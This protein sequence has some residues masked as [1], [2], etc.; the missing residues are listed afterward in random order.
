M[1]EHPRRDGYVTAASCARCHTPLTG[2]TD[3]RYCSHTCRQAAYRTRTATTPAPA[4]PPP[5]PGRTRRQ[6]TVYECGDCGQRLASHQWCTDCQQ[7]ARRI[8]PGGSCPACGEAIT[9]TELNE[10]PMD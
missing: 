5:A 4:A 7:P 6:H 2:R 9:I 1:P 3:H 10:A 8:G